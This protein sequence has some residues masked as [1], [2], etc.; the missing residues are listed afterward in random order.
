MDVHGKSPFKNCREDLHK[1]GINSIKRSGRWNG[2]GK[3][4]QLSG[5]A[6]LYPNWPGNEFPRNEFLDTFFRKEYRFSA[7]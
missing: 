5:D 6:G 2:L 7:Q 1:N 3:Q 4:N